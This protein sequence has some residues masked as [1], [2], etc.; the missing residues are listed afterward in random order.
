MTSFQTRRGFT[1]IEL[2]LVIG[3]V[4]I[5]ASIVIVAMGPAKQYGDAHNAQRNADVNTI[6][7]VVYSYA[8]DNGGA[9]PSDVTITETEICQ[10]GSKHCEGLVDLSALTISGAY[11]DRIPTDPTG[12]SENGTGYEIKKDENGKLITVSAPHAENGETISVHR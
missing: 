8:V 10:S 1:I 2:L 4:A 12:A 9:L 7:N 6:L 11:I 5:L 3:I